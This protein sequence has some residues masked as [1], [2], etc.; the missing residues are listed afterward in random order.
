[1]FIPN[2]EIELSELSYLIWDLCGCM[3]SLP[4]VELTTDICHSV[5]QE[6]NGMETNRNARY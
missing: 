3:Y 5:L 2:F 1:M 4:K 6:W